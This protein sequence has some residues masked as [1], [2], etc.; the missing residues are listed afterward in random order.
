MDHL[1]YN[2]ISITMCEYTRK[3]PT[4]LDYKCRHKVTSGLLREKSIAMMPAQLL[5]SNCMELNLTHPP[6]IVYNNSQA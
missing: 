3:V 6:S 2:V 5:Y 1:N 4:V